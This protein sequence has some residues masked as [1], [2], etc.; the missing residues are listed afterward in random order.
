MIKGVA[1]VMT[2]NDFQLR[3]TRYRRGDEA[4]GFLS[5]I[6]VSAIEPITVVSV[7]REEDTNRG[8]ADD[9]WARKVK[10]VKWTWKGA[11][12]HVMTGDVGQGSVRADWG[13]SSLERDVKMRKT[14]AGMCITV[15]I[16]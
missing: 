7:G 15:N 8:F 6:L 11:R 16:E 12:K 13:S 2:G 14:K 4:F 5:G 9:A 10:E 1:E 3:Y